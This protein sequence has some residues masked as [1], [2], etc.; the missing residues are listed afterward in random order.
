MSSERWMD[1]D[2]VSVCVCV[3]VCVCRILLSHKKEWTNAICN[4]MD[5]PTFINGSKSDKE[6]QIYDFTYMWNIKIWYKIT[7]LQ[8]RNRLIDKEDKCSKSFN[9]GFN[10]MWTENFQMYK[11]DLEK[12]EKPEVI[13]KTSTGS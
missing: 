5:G 9:I 12:V 7:Y 4:N 11:L 13:L 1:Q 2:I 6:R 8:N 10:S 3:C